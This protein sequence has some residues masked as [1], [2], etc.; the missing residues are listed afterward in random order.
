MENVKNKFSSLLLLFSLF[1]AIKRVANKVIIQI[2]YSA[3]LNTT[4]SDINLLNV[5]WLFVS[6][7]ISYA[8]PEKF[9]VNCIKWRRLP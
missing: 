2:N 6:S 3:Y 9:T 4:I 1:D 5:F 7:A 8:V